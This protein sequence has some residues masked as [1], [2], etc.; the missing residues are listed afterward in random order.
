MKRFFIVT[1]VVLLAACGASTSKAAAS[2]TQAGVA[3]WPAPVGTVALK[4]AGQVAE[5]AR[6]DLGLIVF[7]PGIPKDESSHTELRIFPKIR[8][9]EAQY[10]PVLLREALVESNNWG[11][12]RVLPKDDK[13]LELRITGKIIHSD[14]I[15]LVLHLTVTDATG[16]RWLNK[17]YRDQ[18]VAGDYPV[19]ASGNPAWAR[20]D[21]YGD[22]YRQIANDLGQI[23]AGLS[24]AQLAKIR[25]VALLRYAQSL[26]PEA[27]DSFLS[28][29]PEGEYVLKRLPADDDPMIVRVQRIRSQEYLFI[30][31]VDEQY[32]ALYEE[33]GPTYYLWRQYGRERA[34]FKDDYELRAAN[35]DRYGRRGSYIAMERT[36][37][38]FKNSKI[39]DQDLQ[40]LAGGFNN[41]I[42]PTVMEV[43]GRVFRL[44]GGLDA[45]YG[46]WRNILRSIFALETGLPVI[47]K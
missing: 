7:D 33:L 45:Q 39:Q 9:V 32:V 27:F 16:K 42:A 47:E 41:E 31:T 25:N 44:S 26:S 15:N 14:G 5:D 22:I 4:R 19:T 6:L 23:K 10:L 24:R 12:V 38:T 28:T 20:G 21:P 40:E 46:E 8:E 11:V 34:I 37:N 3:T 29:G 36:Y 13:T 30:D 1:A 18:T 43:S 35:R 17:T 2:D